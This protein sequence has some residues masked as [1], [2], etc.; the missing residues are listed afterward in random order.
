M[1]EI[2]FI[3][4]CFFIELLLFIEELIK[5]HGYFILLIHIFLYVSSDFFLLFIVLIFRYKLLLY[6]AQKFEFNYFEK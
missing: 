1:H 6:P 3:L 4:F 5:F 2:L